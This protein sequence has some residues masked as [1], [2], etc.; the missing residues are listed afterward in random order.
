MHEGGPLCFCQKN[1]Q[2]IKTR[3]TGGGE[4][5]FWGGDDDEII[6]GNNFEESM[7]PIKVICPKV[8]D[9]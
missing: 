3:N 8:L 2:F 7:E 4:A 6:G 5:G 1:A 9:Q